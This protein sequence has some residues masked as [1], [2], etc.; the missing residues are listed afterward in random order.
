MDGVEQNVKYVQTNL[1]YD[2]MDYVQTLVIYI[3]NQISILIS[4]LQSTY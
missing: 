4:P 2:K 1:E 3:I